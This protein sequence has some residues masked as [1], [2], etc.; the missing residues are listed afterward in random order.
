MDD[1]SESGDLP[2]DIIERLCVEVDV[3]PVHWRRGRLDDAV[4]RG[5][6]IARY[7]VLGLSDDGRIPLA[8][9]RG[10]RLGPCG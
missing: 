8:E 4:E 10:V 5:E 1:P 3:V 6:P 9:Q 2:S 7:C